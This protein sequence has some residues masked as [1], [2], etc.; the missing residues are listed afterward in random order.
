M[1]GAIDRVFSIDDL[2]EVRREFLVRCVSACPERVASDG[3]DR[4]VVQVCYTCGLAFVDEIA[5]PARGA[6]G[7]AEAGCEFLSL[8]GRP[9][10]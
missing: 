8:K 6:A 1:R 9:D 5:V 10:C 3:R 2:A 7:F 4:V